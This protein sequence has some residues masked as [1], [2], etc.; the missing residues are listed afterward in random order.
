MFS[1]ARPPW[2]THLGRVFSY[3]ELLRNLVAKDLKVKYRGSVLGFFWSLLNP[4]MMIFVYTVV[5]GTFMRLQPSQ[6]RFPLFLIT[7]ILHWNF[8][9]ASFLTATEA[10][11]GNANLVRKIEFPRL[12]LPSASVTF[13][14]V[15]LL[16]ALVVFAVIFP[17]LG[18]KLWIG[19]LMYP[20]VLLL[21]ILTV[22]GFA[23]AMAALTV[24]YR[25]LRHL[26]EVGL[27]ILFWF[28]PIVYEFKIVDLG[29]MTWLRI[30]NP[31]TTYVIVYQDLFYY[32]IWPS[33]ES[34]LGMLA[35]ALIALVGGY[36]IFQKS[37]HRFAEEL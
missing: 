10:V 13:Q 36:L 28:T 20:A 14:L 17:F 12:I 16:F 18:G 33:I 23:M 32:G 27:M 2:V 34:L 22:L 3:R 19:Q 21:Q 1:D 30:L 29:V 6:E 15:Q 4:L 7:G 31:M 8:F 9:S 11:L 35:S 26:S 25:D 24:F 5:I 37:Q